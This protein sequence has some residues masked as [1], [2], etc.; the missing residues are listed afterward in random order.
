MCAEWYCVF[1]AV[2]E[3]FWITPACAGKTPA[4]TLICHLPPDHPRMRGE[5]LSSG[6]TRYWQTGSPPHARGR[7]SI[8]SVWL[9][10]CGGSPPHARGRPPRSRR[11]ARACR[12]TPAC[13]GKTAIPYSYSFS[14]SDHPRMRGEDS[15]T[16]G[17][18]STATG[19]PPHARGRRTRKRNRTLAGGITPACAGKTLRSISSRSRTPDHPR[20]RGEDALADMRGEFEAGSPPHAR[21]RH[22]HYLKLVGR[23][24]ITP[25]C[26]GKT[27]RCVHAVTLCGDHPRMRGEDRV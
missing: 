17:G 4:E 12:I 5:D 23:E 7:R 22:V 6:T 24:G 9:V 19:S 20:M 18:K 14:H 13:A 16:N 25:A 26:A 8:A 11:R 27:V 2:Y 15:K 10:R 1:P 3:D 21:G